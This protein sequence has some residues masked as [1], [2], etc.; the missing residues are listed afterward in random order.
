MLT[1]LARENDL[2]LGN[3]IR[4]KCAQILIVGSVSFSIFYFLLDLNYSALLAAAVGLSVVVPI[5]ADLGG[6]QI[7]QGAVVVAVALALGLAVAVE[8]VA[9]AVA[10]AVL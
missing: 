7:H 8:V 6:P 10:E 3:Y 2:Q 9:V 4:G 1:A 5:V